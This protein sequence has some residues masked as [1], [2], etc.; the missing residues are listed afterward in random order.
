[1]LSKKMLRFYYEDFIKIS[2]LM[3]YFNKDQGWHS[4]KD[5]GS[6]T[7][8]GNRSWR[9]YMEFLEKTERMRRYGCREHPVDMNACTPPISPM[10]Q[11]R[12]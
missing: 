3:L 11:T 9:R 12:V 6:P 7:F 2:K 1:M 10:T 8:S 4:F 5:D